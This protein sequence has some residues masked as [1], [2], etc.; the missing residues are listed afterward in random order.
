M[1]WLLGASRGGP[2]EPAQRCRRKQGQESGGDD[3]A[4]SPPRVPSGPGGPLDGWATRESPRGDRERRVDARG[5]H[6]HTRRAARVDA[7]R[8]ARANASCRG[9]KSTRG[10]S[11]T[12]ALFG[13]NGPP[14]RATRVARVGARLTLESSR[15][16][17]LCKESSGHTRPDPRERG[18]HR[19]GRG[20]SGGRGKGRG[21]SDNGQGAPFIKGRSR[22]VFSVGW[23]VSPVLEQ[24]AT[25]TS[26]G[27]SRRPC[28]DPCGATTHEH[29]TVVSSVIGTRSDRAV[30]DHHEEDHAECLE[31][32]PS[33]AR[34][35]ALVAEDL[36]VRFAD[37]A[38]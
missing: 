9:R 10:S 34:E 26:I 4:P 23:L 29:V 22:L 19:D 18:T 33:V 14:R 28:H 16:P 30:H 31:H 15:V 1:T 21:R 6:E 24:N 38:E 17:H 12:R 25:S 20:A 27:T 2:G 7:T 37:V 3:V 8:D 11:G 36:R 32:H 5:R 13:I 35:G